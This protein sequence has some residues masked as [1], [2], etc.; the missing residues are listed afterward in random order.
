MGF[1]PTPVSANPLIRPNPYFQ[2]EPIKQTVRHV[3]DMTPEEVEEIILRWLHESEAGA[4]D[5]LKAVRSAYPQLLSEEARQILRESQE[6][7]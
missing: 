1:F 5:A 7:D 3:T 4:K 2:R 6:G